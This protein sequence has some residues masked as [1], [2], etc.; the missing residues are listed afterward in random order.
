MSKQN[1]WFSV[2][3]ARIQKKIVGK[4]YSTL[5]VSQESGTRRTGGMPLLQNKKTFSD[6]I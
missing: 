2:C 5:L 4:T 6:S 3:E 1:N